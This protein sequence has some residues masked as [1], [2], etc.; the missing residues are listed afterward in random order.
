MVLILTLQYYLSIT[1]TVCCSEE[2]KQI[3]NMGAI[4]HIVPN[5]WFASFQKLDGGLVSA[6][7]TLVRMKR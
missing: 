4:Y 3:L 1:P 7:D 2:S 5:E 6:I